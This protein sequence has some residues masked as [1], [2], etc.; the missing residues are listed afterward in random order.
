[1]GHH[2]E[3][4]ELHDYRLLQKRLDSMV[5]GAPYSETLMEILKLLFTPED[6]ALAH[7]LPLGIKPLSA[8]ASKLKM[9]Q[10]ELEEKI[11]DMAQRG[12]VFDMEIEGRRFAALAPIVIGFFEFTFMRARDALPM[13][14]L[15]AL[16]EKYMMEEDKFARKV[17]Q[18]PTQIGR[19]LVREEALPEGD[20]TEILD[21][22]RASRL[23]SSASS[24]GVSLCAC[25]HHRSHIGKACERPQRV[26]LSLNFGADPLIKAGLAERIT[27]QEGLDI[28]K[29]CKEAG[30]AQTGD[31]VQRN[32]TYICN[33]CGCCC[34]MIQA[35]KT[36][37]ISHS[38]V[39]S[40]WIMEVD[41]EQCKGC[42]KCAEACPLEAITIRE[43]REGEKKK[44]WAEVDENVCMGCGVCHSACK[45]GG[46][47]L[48][49]RA[50]RVY[51]P[52]TAFDKWI[53]MALERG[54]LAPLMLDNAD[55]FSHR[56]LGRIFSILEK[57]PPY[58]VAMAIAPL[59]S[60]FLNTIVQKA[61][62]DLGVDL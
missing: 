5:T 40:N 14:E 60:A 52:E 49:P 10:Q 4:K 16:F 44:R 1:M 53:A 29:Q 58:K 27:N 3:L 50:Q 19:S 61:R 6:A 21:W 23:V 56:A 18:G 33:C 34:G 43:Q 15:A 57:T 25:R 42:G 7:K 54:K 9:P 62:R 55:R 26:C 30:L 13:K 20:F 11:T 32:A 46:V 41:R 38:I 39:S 51:T 59:R 12:L 48:K 17:F 24:V 37:N 45:Y 31:N 8:I 35:Y 22:E 28:L 47:K 36:F 2:H